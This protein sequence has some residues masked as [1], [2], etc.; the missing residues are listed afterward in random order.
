MTNKVCG[1]LLFGICALS[2]SASRDHSHTRVIGELNNSDNATTKNEV[3]EV[4]SISERV[5]QLDEQ[6]I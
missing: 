3:Y 4:S 1:L 2:G 6:L 5:L